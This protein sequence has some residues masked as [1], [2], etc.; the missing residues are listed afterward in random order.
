MKPIHLSILL[1]LSLTLAM[2][3]T[4]RAQENYL[5]N[6]TNP[7]LLY[8]REFSV[9]PKVDSKRVDE[10]LQSL[11]T[12]KD[13]HDFVDQFDATFRRLSKVRRF[14]GECDWGD[15][16]G[17]GPYLL[18][19]YLSKAR[20]IAKVTQLRARV[21]FEKGNDEQ[22]VDE[23]L[24]VYVLGGHL[25]NSPILINLLVHYSMDKICASIIAEN[26]F[27]FSSDSLTK[28]RDGIIASPR[29]KSIADTIPTERHFMAGWLRRQLSNLTHQ[30]PNDTSVAFNKAEALI[31]Q[32]FD[33]ENGDKIW[34]D[35]TTAGGTSIDAIIG[36]LDSSNSD[37]EQLE[38]LFRKPS[39]EFLDQIGQFDTATKKSSN[40][41]RRWLFPSLSKSK[42]K[43][44]G[45]Q[46][47]YEM[48]QT[49]IQSRLV[50]ESAFNLA[51]DAIGGGAFDKSTFTHEGQ[52]AGFILR[53]KFADPDERQQ[54][55]LLQPL[56]GFVLSGPKIGTKI[57][58]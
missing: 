41:V 16:L 7:A 39:N 43:E 17:E 58:D 2:R 20:D 37:Y 45:S 44:I 51:K 52:S 28:L 5:P 19:P 11:D 50:G 4:A 10:M 23:L 27:R 22:V 32:M 3:E 56:R 54:L 57:S 25:A 34:A 47:L 8:W 24:S 35:F 55:F 40:P 53:S 15:D 6:E 36:L 46:V 30:F 12:S 13:D 29:G 26:L 21:H 42:T 48:V 1:L 14:T 18:L 9:M 38:S 33:A 31:R 49:A